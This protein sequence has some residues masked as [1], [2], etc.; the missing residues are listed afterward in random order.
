MV[1][2]SEIVGGELSL[3]EILEKMFGTDVEEVVCSFHRLRR[4]GNLYGKKPK[5][6]MNPGRQ[7]LVVV[8]RV[9]RPL[10]RKVSNR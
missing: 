8:C 10:Y 6:R 4:S 2:V 7:K 9:Y 5:C 3:K 1:E